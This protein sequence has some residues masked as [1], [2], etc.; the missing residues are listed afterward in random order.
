MDAALAS[1]ASWPSEDQRVDARD[2]IEALGNLLYLI[3]QDAE[4]PALVRSYT[5]QAEERISVLR[6]LLP[7]LPATRGH[8]GGLRVVTMQSGSQ[9]N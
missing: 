1:G 6:T 9:E 5:A 8:H 3:H 4:K 2:I 7:E